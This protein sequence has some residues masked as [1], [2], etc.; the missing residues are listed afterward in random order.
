MIS[1]RRQQ[2]GHTARAYKRLFLP[3]FGP[4]GDLVG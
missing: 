1:G 4:I 2:N 3:H